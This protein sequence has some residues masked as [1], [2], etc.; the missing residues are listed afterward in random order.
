MSG[1]HTALII[2]DSP[3]MRLLVSALLGHIGCRVV[4][5][6]DGEAG[7]ELA[8]AE[9]PSLIC[10][11]VML[12]VESGFE[13]CE[14]LKRDP[15]TAGIPVLIMSSRALP[16][17]R[18]AA[19]YAGADAFLRKPIDRAAFLTRVEALLARGRRAEA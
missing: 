9:Q 1:G 2:D 16:E 11:D 15:A 4:V 14:A 5:A 17:D 3:E 7:L 18:A 10:L 6:G 19:A 13:V 8:R 12:P